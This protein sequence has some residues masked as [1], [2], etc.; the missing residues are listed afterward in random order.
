M[1]I[2]DSFAAKLHSTVV[3]ATLVLERQLK[4]GVVAI[5]GEKLIARLLYLWGSCDYFTFL[6]PPHFCRI[7][8]PSCK[9]FA[10]KE[11]HSL[12]GA[13]LWVAEDGDGKQCQELVA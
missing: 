10:V 1:V 5:S 4:V 3:R 13:D 7:A 6:D 2:W 8:L 12:C 9:G 11:G